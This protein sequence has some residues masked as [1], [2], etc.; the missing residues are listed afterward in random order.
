MLKATNQLVTTARKLGGPAAI[1]GAFALGAALF[2]GH[3]HVHAAAAMDEDSVSAL[4]SLDHAM[5]AVASK[6]TPAVVNVAVTS[7]GPSEELS[8]GQMQNLPPGLRQYLGPM[9]PQMPSQPQFEHGVGS[10]IIVSP[11]GYIVTNSHVVDGAQQI[12]V[13]LN[14]RRVLTG[15]V[16]GV[17]KMTDL[18]VIKVNAS[19]LPT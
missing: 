1:L 19:D 6:V 9:M 15:K 2:V 18:A 13:T 14:D 12:K 5:E 7:R 4:T 16:V 17:E 10:G 3:G 11:D 8:E